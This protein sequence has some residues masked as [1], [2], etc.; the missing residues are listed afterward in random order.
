MERRCACAELAAA[1][2]P[3]EV[4]DRH[5]PE[6][7]LSEFKR[8]A[9]RRRLSDGVDFVD[10]HA[11]P[12]IARAM[13]IDRTSSFSGGLNLNAFAA[14]RHGVV[15]IDALYDQIRMTVEVG[16]FYEAA[17]VFRQARG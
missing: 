7:D 3:S 16:D 13:C 15:R 4:V 6:I 1:W 2:V 8:A 9:I 14:R 12:L 5:L 11:H 10:K 17:R